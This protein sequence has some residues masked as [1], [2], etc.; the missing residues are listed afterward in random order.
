M[1]AADTASHHPTTIT[2]A[3]AERRDRLKGVATGR[4]ALAAT[5]ADVLAIRHPTKCLI[6]DFDGAPFSREWKDAR[7][8]RFCPEAQ[9]RQ[10][11][12]VARSSI[13]KRA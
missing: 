9:P 7:W 3:R 5:T 10:R 12:S 8:A 4:A 11:R 6:P 1:L 2:G 13:V